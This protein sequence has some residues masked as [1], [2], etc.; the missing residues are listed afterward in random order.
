MLFE[1]WVNVI[2]S[3][4]TFKQHWFNNCIKYNNII[5]AIFSYKMFGFDITSK[6]IV[7]HMIMLGARRVV[8][9]YT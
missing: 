8:K 3:G 4:S 6:A 7:G 9:F 2:D 5:K 1:F